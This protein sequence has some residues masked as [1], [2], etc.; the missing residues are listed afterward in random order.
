VDIYQVVR[1][2]RS[3]SSHG[4]FFEEVSA[5]INRGGLLHDE[6]LRYQPLSRTALGH[7]LNPQARLSFRLCNLTQRRKSRRPRLSSRNIAVDIRQRLSRVDGD[8]ALHAIAAQAA[9]GVREL[10]PPAGTTV[11]TDDRAPVEE[12]TRRM[13]HSAGDAFFCER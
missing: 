3:I 12:I 10:I 9:E 5:H 1:T 13:L 4:E 7:R 8:A 2:S 11:F 6:R